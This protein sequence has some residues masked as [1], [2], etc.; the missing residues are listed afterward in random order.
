MSEYTGLDGL[1]Q[2]QRDL[3]QEKIDFLMGEICQWNTDFLCYPTVNRINLC[4]FVDGN[5]ERYESICKDI[6]DISQ[7]L[8]ADIENL[9]DMLQQMEKKIKALQSYDTE[10]ESGDFIFSIK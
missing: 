1:L 5:Q 10:L 7:S 6:K 2:F 3:L 4:V 9:Y 8:E